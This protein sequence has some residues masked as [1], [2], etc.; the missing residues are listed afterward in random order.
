MTNNGIFKYIVGGFLVNSM[1]NNNSSDF[2]KITKTFINMD[3]QFHGK[4]H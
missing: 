1:V 4:I 3:T 2:L